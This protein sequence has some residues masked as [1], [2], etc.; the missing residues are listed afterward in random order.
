M[1]QSLI[2]PLP[3]IVFG[4][5]DVKLRGPLTLLNNGHTGGLWVR[6]ISNGFER[7]LLIAWQLTW[8]YQKLLTATNPS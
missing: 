2:V 7:K 4:N 3:R 1:R 5:Y 8:R 6:E